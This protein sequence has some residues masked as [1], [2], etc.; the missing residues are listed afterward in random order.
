MFTISSGFIA[1]FKTGDNINH[2]L[3]IL[4]V[5][6]AQYEKGSPDEKRLLC[7]PIVVIQISIIEAA[8]QDFHVRCSK[9][10]WERVTNLA[11]GVASYIRGKKINKLSQYVQSAK[12]HDLFGNANG[13]LYDELELL[14]K[15]RNRVHIQNENKDLEPD[16]WNAFT[17]QRK[18]LAE[19]VL[20]QV[21]KTL[22]K[23]YPRPE[24]VAGFVKDFEIPWI[25]RM[26]T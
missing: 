15:L 11:E 19:R 26:S 9:F 25:E 18:L 21:I 14:S 16:D 10:T 23:K 12:K 22:S 3:R 4:K 24:H 1:V 5:L 17:S 6:Y 8:L 2:N 20:E 7:K 13:Q